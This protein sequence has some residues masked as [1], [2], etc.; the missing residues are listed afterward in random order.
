MINIIANLFEKIYNIGNKRRKED[1]MIL[2]P[3]SSQ[4]SIFLTDG[5]MNPSR[6]TEDINNKFAC[7]FT[8]E[9]Y[10]FNLEDAPNDMPL[11][12]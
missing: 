8:K 3:F 1:K 9:N 10:S 2:K 7:I 5:V 12:R 11:V 6:I 4:I